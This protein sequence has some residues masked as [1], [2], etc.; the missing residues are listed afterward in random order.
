MNTDT[1]F[2]FNDLSGKTIVLTGATSGIGHAILPDF[3]RQGL[4]LIL[5]GRNPE[6]LAAVAAEHA[7]YKE[8][9]QTIT[10]ELSD[11]KS[12]EEACDQ[13]LKNNSAIDGFISNAAIDPRREFEDISTQFVRNVMATNLE[14]SFHI[15]QKLIPLLKKSPAGRIILIG[16]ITY[17]LGGTYMSAYAASKGALIGLTRSLAHELYTTNITVNCLSPGAIVVKKEGHHPERD[18]QLID[19]QSVPRRLTPKDIIGPLSLLLSDAGGG[20]S[21]QVIKVEGGVFHPLA[22]AKLQKIRLETDSTNPAFK[23]PE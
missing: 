17:D 10:C 6:K 15:T 7:S 16:S 22:S 14:P 4:N 19:L 9:I 8:Q 2:Q 20:I 18:Q 5:M 3:L 21:G 13:I 11:P 1:S 12:R 23:D